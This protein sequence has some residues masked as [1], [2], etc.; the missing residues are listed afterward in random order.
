M[1]TLHRSLAAQL[2]CISLWSPAPSFA[3]IAITQSGAPINLDESL[4]HCNS[5]NACIEASGLSISHNNPALWTINDDSDWTMYQAHTSSALGSSIDDHFIPTQGR[6]AP[7]IE[8]PDFEGVAAAC[9]A[10]EDCRN[11]PLIYLVDE[12]RNAIIPVDYREKKYHDDKKV[13]QMRGAV[14]RLPT[15]DKFCGTCRGESLTD[16]L[17]NAGNSGLEG[18]TFSP[19]HNSFFVLKEK[20]PGL[21]IKIS[22]DL[23]II[24]QVWGLDLG[25]SCGNNIDIDYSGL[26]HDPSRCKTTADCEMWLVSDEAETVYLLD[27]SDSKINNKTTLN[28][29]SVN[30]SQSLGHK[31]SEGIAYDH[32]TDQLYIVV[33]GGKGAD[34]CGT[35]GNHSYLYTYHV[36]H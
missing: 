15:T 1:Q 28:H 24:E 30:A 22:A 7:K 21:L 18:I 20:K 2:L 31:C 9:R 19:A 6:N 4:T 23:N 12:Q 26:S 33:D 10:G 17:N 13:A 27:I 36:S 34:N 14:Q 3:D 29:S 25:D 11:T 8:A 32:N 35:P 16:C 5:S